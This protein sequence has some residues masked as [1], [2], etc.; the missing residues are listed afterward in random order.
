MFYWLLLI[1]VSFF[2]LGVFLLVLFVLWNLSTDFHKID[3][4]LGEAAPGI[5]WLVFR[6]VWQAL[7]KSQGRVS[8]K[9]DK[10]LSSKNN[11]KSAGNFELLQASLQVFWT[12]LR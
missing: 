12:S 11:R 5:L 10:V 6:V 2:L 1:L 7:F 4:K 8:E 3:H 9:W